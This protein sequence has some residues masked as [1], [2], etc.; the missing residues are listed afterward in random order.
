[1]LIYPSI[2]NPENEKLQEMLELLDGPTA[3]DDDDEDEEDN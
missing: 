1:V 3:N 2:V